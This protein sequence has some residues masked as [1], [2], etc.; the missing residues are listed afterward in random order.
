MDFVAGTAQNGFAPAAGLVKFN[1][2]QILFAASNPAPLAGG[3]S[4]VSTANSADTTAGLVTWN[5]TTLTLPVAFATTGQNRAEQWNGVIVAT[6]PEPSSIALLSLV[7]MIGCVYRRR[8][9]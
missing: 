5:G 3:T 9:V 6:I 1:A 7:G 2:G 4:N 8:S